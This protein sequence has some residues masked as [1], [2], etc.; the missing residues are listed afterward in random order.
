MQLLETCICLVHGIERFYLYISGLARIPPLG[1]LPPL[2]LFFL[3]MR[4]IAQHDFK[5]FRRGMRGIDRAAEAIGD[6]ARQHAG[7]VD[8]GMGKQHEVDLAR[9][10]FEIGIVLVARFTPPLKHAAIHQEAH[11]VR[12]Q[13]ITGARHLSAGTMELNFHCITPELAWMLLL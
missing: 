10:E 12:F 9:A 3:N 5:Q 4:R 7:M 2:S 6:E 8:M 1:I 13:H 11:T